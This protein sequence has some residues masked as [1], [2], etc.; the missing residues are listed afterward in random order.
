M[1]N[2][3]IL[4][5]IQPSGSLCI[6][7]YLG[8]MKNWVELQEEY[9]S[10][11]LI[12]DLHSITV[13][14]VPSELR[15]RCLS[16]AA[17]YIACGIDPDKSLI[18]IQ[19]HIHQHVE[20]MWILSTIAYTGE[21]SRMTQYKDKAKNIPN[22]N[23]GLY[24][25]PVLMAS[26]ILLYQADLVPVGADQKQ[27]IELARDLAGRFNSKYSETFKIPDPYIP[28]NINRIMSLQNPANKM[29]KSDENQNNIIALLDPP[30]VINNKIK[31]AV[32]DSNSEIV[33]FNNSQSIMN[34]IAI[35]SGF[36]DLSI[37]QIE[38]N[39]SGKKYSVLKNDLSELVIEKLKVIQDEYLRIINDKQYL[40]DVLNKSSEKASFKAKKTI[41]KV[42]RK[43]G[44]VLK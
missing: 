14:Q 10:I 4:S 37:K 30:N 32:T 25:Y 33:P 29:S 21:L 3:I 18:A 26:D 27:H 39:Y 24:S 2:K 20:L 22:S 28:D 11:F 17:Q 13:K 36:S 5:G 38:E 16:F 9:E 35:Y 7:N 43:V 31:R 44:F 12:V 8:A 19:S 15:N 42:Y 23:L 6:A 1:N 40:H 41:S 34:L